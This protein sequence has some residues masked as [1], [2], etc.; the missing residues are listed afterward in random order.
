MNRA[1]ALVLLGLDKA[2]CDLTSEIITTAFRRAAVASH[3]DTAQPLTSQG[4]SVST[5]HDMDALRLAKKKLLDDTEGANNACAQ[6]R[7]RGTVRH[8][9]GN[10]PCGACKGTG[11]KYGR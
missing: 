9:L 10:R 6:C 1:Q 7:G 3:P 8:K 5:R 4:E 2:A 11:D